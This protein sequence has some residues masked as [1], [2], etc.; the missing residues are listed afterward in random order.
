MRPDTNLRVD[1]PRSAHF[2]V[3]TFGNRSLP[4]PLA[5]STPQGNSLW[6]AQFDI[7]RHLLG[8][9]GFLRCVLHDGL[10]RETP[11][12][13]YSAITTTQEHSRRVLNA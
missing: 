12:F 4:D 7:T 13:V 6:R 10:A 1:P 11:T 9:G 5:A 3:A 2:T 8:Q